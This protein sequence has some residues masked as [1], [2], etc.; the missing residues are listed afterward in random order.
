MADIRRAMSLITGEEPTPQQVQRVQALA[1]SLDIPNNDPMLPILIALDTYHG[2]F[3]KLPEKNRMAANEAA[4]ISAKM[5]KQHIERV[6]A[7]AVTAVTPT[8]NAAMTRV[9]DT[10][11]KNAGATVT[12]KF[13]TI[14]VG[15]AT[16]AVIGSVSFGYALGQKS[17]AAEATTT[18]SWM[19]TPAGQAVYQ[20]YLASPLFVEWTGTPE[21][22]S[23]YAMRDEIQ[24]FAECSK[25]GWRKEKRSGRTVCFPG[26][27]KDGN[28]YGWVMP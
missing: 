4:D 7:E 26:T 18:A 11:S 24:A 10:V 20:N 21:A 5:A 28:V 27:A 2:A 15:I 16:L 17:M 6:T 9:A 25:A 19:T 22:R 12:A 8:L 13:I 3:S 1:H 23:A 14:A